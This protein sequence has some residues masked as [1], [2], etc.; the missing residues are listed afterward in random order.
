MSEYFIVVEEDSLYLE[1][2]VNQRIDEGWEPIG[3]VC[4]HISNDEHVNNEWA[5]AMIRRKND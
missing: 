2:A 1:N 4:F 3:G 5:Q